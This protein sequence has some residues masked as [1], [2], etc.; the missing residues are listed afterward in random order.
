MDEGLV[1]GLRLAL[2]SI[3]SLDRLTR[4]LVPIDFSP[5]SR[6]ALT[7]ALSL[8]NRLGGSIDVLYVWEPRS[9]VVEQVFEHVSSGDTE[10]IAEF[11]Q[12]RAGREMDRLLSEMRHLG[13]SVRGRLG[14]GDAANAIL[15]M[16]EHE[17]YDLIVMG[18]HG[19]TG[20]SHLV[21]GSV[22]EKVVARA[23]CPVL[24]I[25]Q[26]AKPAALTLHGQLFR[27]V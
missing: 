24:T 7:E 8:S 23:P 5:S 18:T 20:L 4:I 16:A 1:I 15:R 21:M 19:R 2:R 13:V 12:T 14:S 9:F 25:R 17:S 27:R 6:A 10:A 11:A 26:N 22:A 3:M